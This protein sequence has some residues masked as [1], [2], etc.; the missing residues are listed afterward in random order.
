MSKQEIVN[1]FHRALDNFD[2]FEVSEV[3]TH[4]WNIESDVCVITFLF[5]PFGEE[6]NIELK[7]KNIEGSSN[8]LNF[9]LLRFLRGAYHPDREEDSPEYYASLLNEFYADLLAGD[10]SIRKIYDKYDPQFFIKL[11]DLNSLA[12]DDPIR[13]KA[14]NFDISWIEDL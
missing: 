6:F 11:I 12:P 1:R 10:F 13:K 5:E 9:L 7:E 8:P 14:D 4:V 2:Q 3:N